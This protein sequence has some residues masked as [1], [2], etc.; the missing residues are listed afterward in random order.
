MASTTHPNFNGKTEGKEV[1]EAFKDVVVG[2]TIM[3]TGVNTGGIGFSTSQAL[4]SQSPKQIIITGRSPDKLKASIDA[5]K[6]DFPN[7]DYRSLQV[8]LSSQASV[9]K[10]AAEVLSWTDVPTIDIVINSAG[11]MGVPERTFTVD[12][13]EMHFGT[14]VIG[15]FLLTNLIM[16]KIIAAAKKNPKGSTRIVNV[17]SQSPEVSSIRWSDMSFDKKNKD[18]PASEQPDYGW[19]HD[20]G[21]PDMHDV[22]YIPIDGYHRS[23]VGNVLF[24]IALN[25]RLFTSHG[26]FSTGVHPGVIGTELGRNFSEETMKAIADMNASGRFVPKTLGAG[27]SNS[28]TAALDPKLAQGV[29]E[30]RDGKENWG[31]YL[32]DCQ[33]SGQANPLAVSSEE[34]EKLWKHCEGVVGETF[35]W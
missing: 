30:A 17:S 20:W 18:L 9:R 28:L 34:A 10:A 35:E 19:L 2:K 22:A 8:D 12:G 21:Y 5:L 15:H 16:P 26:I 31:A 32:V 6:S 4:A 11:I 27:A 13:V 29:G 24:G 33:I 25:N 23:K 7:V 1:T 3:V 14:N